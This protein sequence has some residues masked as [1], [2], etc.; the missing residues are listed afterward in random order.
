M[1]K[2]NLV[3]AAVAAIAMAGPVSAKTYYVGYNNKTKH[4]VVTTKKPLGKTSSQVGAD[5]YTSRQDAMA[6]MKAAAD[7]Q[8]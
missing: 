4:C 1:H 3:I 2:F 7:C 8:K 5:T 6:A